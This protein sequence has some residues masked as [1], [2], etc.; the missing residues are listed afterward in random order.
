MDYEE[1]E[2]QKTIKSN[3]KT[4][5]IPASKTIKLALSKS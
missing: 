2:E 5:K 3:K 1:Y 4:I